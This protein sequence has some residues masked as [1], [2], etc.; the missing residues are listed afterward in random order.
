MSNIKILD[1]TFNGPFDYTS[2]RER[3]FSCVYAIFSNNKLVYVGQ[4]K[5]INKRLPSH[6]KRECWDK[7]SSNSKSLYVFLESSED[8]RKLIEEEILQSHTTCCN[9]YSS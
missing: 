2:E 1:Y 7:H 9:E 4:T 5:D 6:H 3:T 8:K